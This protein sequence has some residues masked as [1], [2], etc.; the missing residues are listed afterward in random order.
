MKEKSG[1][2]EIKKK[3]DQVVS[4]L[5]SNQQN[6]EALKANREYRKAEETKQLIKQEERDVRYCVIVWLMD[7]FN[8]TKDHSS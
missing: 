4:E 7:D 2:D 1:I 5:T 8:G 6:L 3:K